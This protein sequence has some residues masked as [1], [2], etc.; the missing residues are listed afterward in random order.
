MCKNCVRSY[1]IMSQS[2]GTIV[3]DSITF[4][5]SLSL[6]PLIL[7]RLRLIRKLRYQLNCPQRWVIASPVKGAT[8]R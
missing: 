3:L 8:Y 2:I 5:A 7:S 1:W 4:G 6:S